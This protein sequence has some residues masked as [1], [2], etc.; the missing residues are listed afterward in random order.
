MTGQLKDLVTELFTI[1]GDP[2]ELCYQELLEKAFNH[3]LR[4]TGDHDISAQLAND[5]VEEYLAQKG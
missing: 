4:K 2:E 5:A 1:Q 3:Y